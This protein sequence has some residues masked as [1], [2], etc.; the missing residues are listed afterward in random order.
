MQQQIELENVRVNNLQDVCLDIPHGQLIALC[1]LSGSGKS[2]LAFDTLYAEGQRRY[3]E[4][5]SPHTR[6]FVNQLDRPDADRIDGIPPAIAVKAFR[7]KVGRKSTV[8]TA[9]EVTEYLRLVMA[10]IGNVVCPSCQVP[11]T[12][13]DPQSVAQSLD[14][15]EP[16][17]RY[18]IV[19]VS[20]THLT[21]PTTPYV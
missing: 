17:T 19:S 20:Y 21:L 13:N 16:G 4:S 8:G 5:L 12:R 6:K 11:V 18:Q 10:Q 7:G 15:L 14:E 1:G 9:A 2:S 3:I